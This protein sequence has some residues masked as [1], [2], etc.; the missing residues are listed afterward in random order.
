ME[1]LFLKIKEN[2]IR[3][4]KI[5]KKLINFTALRIIIMIIIIIFISKVRIKENKN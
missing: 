4:Y 3:F 1:I 5:R 2:E